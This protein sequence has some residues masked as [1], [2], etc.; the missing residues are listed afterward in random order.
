MR[1]RWL[2]RSVLVACAIA[3][4]GA[5]SGGTTPAPPP[6]A[7]GKADAVCSIRHRATVRINL[8][9]EGQGERSALVHIPA[10][11]RAQ[12]PLVLALH[13]A[14][15]TGAGMERYSGLSDVAD[16]NGFAVA[17]PDAAGPRWRIS[18]Q[19]G[20]DDVV[21]LDLLVQKLV[22]G[23][24]VKQRRV[25]VAGVSNGAGMAAR[26]ACEADEP[27]AGLVSVAGGYA[28]LPACAAP[29]P[30]SVLEIHGTADTVVPYA[31]A[32]RTG[33][34]AVMTWL[35]GW[36]ARDGCHRPPGREVVRKRVVR[37]EWT[38]CR[39]GIAVEHLRLIGG[40]HAW[41]G[42]NPLDAGPD[43]GVSAARSAWSF[44]RGRTATN[45]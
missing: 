1:R 15:G 7:P 41:P 27:L 10:Q 13:G 5:G 39:A 24:C 2:A 36:V 33:A 25:S 18:S 16:R 34:G 9:I 3:A 21:F 8:A 20:E 28:S 29:R 37:F 45:S 30:L 4:V 6:A 12:V 32:P 42:A 26:F 19:E 38:G 35:R 14:G 44:L 23:G 17:Y 31:G 11:R 43:L 40:T 22:A